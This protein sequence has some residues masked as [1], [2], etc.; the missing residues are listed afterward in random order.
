[1]VEVYAPPGS[2]LMTREVSCCRVRPQPVQATAACA[3]LQHFAPPH[4]PL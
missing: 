2:G 1:M 4:P 3:G